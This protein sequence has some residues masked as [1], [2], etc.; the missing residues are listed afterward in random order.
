M[1]DPRQLA[2]ETLLKLQKHQSYS[3]LSIAGVL[4]SSDLSGADKS[5]FTTLVYGVLERKLTLDYNLSLY[6]KQPLKKLNPNAYAALLLGAYQ[7]LKRSRTT[8]PSTRA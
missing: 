3:N 5:F 7:V 1:K 4:G 6:L 2:F 8:P